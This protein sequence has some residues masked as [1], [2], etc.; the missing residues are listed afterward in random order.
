MRGR[1]SGAGPVRLL[2]DQAA[3]PPSRGAGDG[4]S[5]HDQPGSIGSAPRTPTCASSPSSTSTS[6]DTWT[7]ATT[8]FRSRVQP[9]MRP[10]R[11]IKPWSRS[12]VQRFSRS[13][14][15]RSRLRPDNTGITCEGR[16]L[17]QSR[18]SSGSSHCW[19]ARRPRTQDR[20]HAC[21]DCITGGSASLGV[22]PV[23]FRGRTAQVSSQEKPDY[24]EQSDQ[25]RGRKRLAP[26]S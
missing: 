13:A 19:A 6:L 20:V 8:W 23:A 14:P 25:E 1:P 24:A 3:P 9:D 16:A 18:T 5:S 10:W 17:W 22:P 11:A 4:D 26:F 2:L 7:F 21:R 12:L 15:S